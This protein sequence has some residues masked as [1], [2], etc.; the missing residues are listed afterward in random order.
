VTSLDLRVGALSL[1]GNPGTSRTLR[2]VFT[3]AGEPVTPGP[4]SVWI[5]GDERHPTDFTDATEHPAAVAGNEATVTVQIP[6]G[7]ELLRV[8]IDGALA[9]VGHVAPSLRGTADQEQTVQVNLGALEVHLDLAAVPV[10][11]AQQLE[12]LAQQLAALEAI[13]VV[14]TPED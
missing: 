3:A 11:L 12:D 5:G 1:L 10:D 7:R 14:E 2:L 13:A 8:T 6:A 4:V 9:T